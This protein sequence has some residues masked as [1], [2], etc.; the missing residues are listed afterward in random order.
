MNQAETLQGIGGDF[1]TGMTFCSPACLPEGQQY[2]VPRF[3]SLA[4][5]SPVPFSSPPKP[6]CLPCTPRETHDGLFSL[7]VP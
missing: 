6:P 7:E 4:A 2:G 3:L 1:V 5:V